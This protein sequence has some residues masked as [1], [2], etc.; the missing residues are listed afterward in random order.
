MFC[1]FTNCSQRVKTWN[2]VCVCVSVCG[3]GLTKQSLTNTIY[4]ERHKLVEYLQLDYCRGASKET[5]ERE[6]ERATLRHNKNKHY[7]LEYMENQ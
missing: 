4:S 2:L 1:G 3:A 5:K 6:R 7:T